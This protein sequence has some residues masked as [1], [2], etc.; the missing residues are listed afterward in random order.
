MAWQSILDR[1]RPVG[2]PGPAAAAGVPSQDVTGPA[3]ELAPVMAALRPDMEAAAARLAAAEAEAEQIVAR[4]R[5]R[6]ATTLAT[7]RSRAPGARAKAA[8]AA[9]RDAVEQRARWM[10]DARVRADAMT[11]RAEQVTPRLVAR[12][13]DRVLD[14]MLGEPGAGRR[15]G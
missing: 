2:A 12:A 15:S 13:L 14:E 1:F 4:A 3:A 10:A 11:A 5:E 6:A 8:A 7:A 9:E